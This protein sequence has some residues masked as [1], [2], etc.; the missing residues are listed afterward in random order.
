MKELFS[1]EG[2]TVLVTGATGHL[3]LAM[4]R[5]IAESGAHVLLNG[6]SPDRL[7]NAADKLAESGLNVSAIMFDVRDE[8]SIAAAVKKLDRLDGIVNNAY[9]G[10]AGTLESATEQDFESAYRFNVIA[11]FNLAKL[12]L[13]LLKASGKASIVNIASMYGSVSPDPAIYGNSGKN[14][15]PFYGA[16]KGG[17]IQLTRYMACHWAE[18]GIR[19]NSISPGPFPPQDIKES[20]PAFHEELCRKNPMHRIGHADELIGPV[21]FLLSDASSFVTGINLPVDG[22]WTAW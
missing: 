16:S 14:N 19:V 10:T 4:A 7:R 18:H 6:H 21:C 13:P 12:A 3:G 9:A 15:P 17:M 1:L 22:G 2:K 20:N 8:G 11:P 5:G